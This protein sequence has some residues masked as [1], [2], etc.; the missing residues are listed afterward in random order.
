[1]RIIQSFT[2]FALLLAF[3]SC[4][5][6]PYDTGDGPLSGMRA[7]FVEAHTDASSVI[8]E[9]STDDD[10]SLPLT[11]GIKTKW[12]EKA[13]ASYRA[14][15]YYDVR[16]DAG[17]GTDAARPIAITQVVTPEVV[18]AADMKEPVMTDPVTLVSAWKSA[19]NKYINFDM[20]L[21][22]GRDGDDGSSQKIGIVC[23]EV[24]RTA[25]DRQIVRL[26]LCHNQNGV[27]EYY[28]AKLYL[29]IPVPFLPVR[30]SEGDE[31]EIEINTYNGTVTRTFVF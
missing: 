7:D 8:V 22:T 30:L 11:Q 1:M 29:S 20:G 12:A 5:N 31:V 28:T 24:V 17:S 4:S 23:D 9:V 21:K 2:L 26:R 3:V 14:L 18:M 25:D 6:D 19:N 10:V 16:H 27:P 15:L 13:N